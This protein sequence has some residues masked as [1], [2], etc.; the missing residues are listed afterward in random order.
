MERKREIKRKIRKFFL[1]VS[2]VIA[3]AMV[4]LGLCG[5]EG[6]ADW[7]Q[8]LVLEGIGLVWLSLLCAANHEIFYADKRKRRNHEHVV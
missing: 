4:F 8:I 6:D 7:K 2:G 3:G 1:Q 5:I